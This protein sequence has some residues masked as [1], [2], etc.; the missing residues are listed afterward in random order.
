[1][2]GGKQW[3]PWVHINDVVRVIQWALQD[4]Q[5][6]GPYNLVAPQPIRQKDFATCLG[7]VLG[8]PACLPAPAFALRMALGAMADEALFASTRAL[9]QRLQQQGFEFQWEEIEAAIR[10]L[11]DPE[12]SAPA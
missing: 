6:R 3:F 4:A 11:L 2:G 7:R 12:S 9:P 8:R 5:A 1:M 10:D